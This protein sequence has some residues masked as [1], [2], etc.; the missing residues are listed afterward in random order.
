MVG[1]N[2]NA[3]LSKIYLKLRDKQLKGFPGGTVDKNPPS[4][5]GDTGLIFDLGRFHMLRSN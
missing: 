3:A 5:T 2:I 1:G 4:S